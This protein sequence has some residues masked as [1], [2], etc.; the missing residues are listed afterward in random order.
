MKLSLEFLFVALVAS[1]VQL[2]V[3]VFGQFMI[4]R[5]VVVGPIIGWLLGIPQYGLLIGI[6]SE[7]IYISVIPVGIK[8]PPDA[9]VSTVFTV[10]SYKLTGG[11]LSTS[12]LIGIIIGILYKQL[13]LFT[14]SISSMVLGWV[15]TAKDEVLIRRINLLVVYGIVTTYIKTL[16]FYL[17]MFP[18]VSYGL[19]KFCKFAIPILIN[20][21]K[22]LI[23]IL[24]AIGIGIG[25]SHLTER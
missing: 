23:Y 4:H 6:I 17:I 25:M 9:T 15:D 8:V 11:C 24:P 16:L 10:M 13:D 14:R 2:D 5:P 22:S 20:I 3:L 12:I 7:L 1:V 21:E 19:L 18:V